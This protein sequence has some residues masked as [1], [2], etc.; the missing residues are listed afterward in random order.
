VLVLLRLLNFCTR[1]CFCD[2][3]GIVDKEQD[4]E[5]WVS[6]SQLRQVL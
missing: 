6:R 4:G 2:L 1:V 5:C 3:P